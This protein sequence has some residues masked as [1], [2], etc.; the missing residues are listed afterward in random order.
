MKIHTSDVNTEKNLK[1][2]WHDRA[3]AKN[4]TFDDESSCTEIDS[5]LLPPLPNPKEFSGLQKLFHSEKPA[6]ILVIYEHSII[7]SEKD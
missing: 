6:R 3:A 1:Q 4:F 5:G 2:T 7:L